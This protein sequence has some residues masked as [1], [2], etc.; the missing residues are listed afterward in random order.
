MSPSLSGCSED[1]V[2][3]LLHSTACLVV[4]ATDQL[5]RTLLLLVAPHLSWSKENEST[6][7]MENEE[8]PLYL[9]GYVS[10]VLKLS[11]LARE[12]RQD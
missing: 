12:K 8:I 2:G 5:S 7:A 3:Y 11:V 1:G 6:S 4:S 9:D 10:F